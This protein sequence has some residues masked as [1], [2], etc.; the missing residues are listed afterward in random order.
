MG[1]T[2]SAALVRRILLNARYL[3]LLFLGAVNSAGR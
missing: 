3:V 1:L 2:H